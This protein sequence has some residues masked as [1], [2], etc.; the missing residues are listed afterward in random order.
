MGTYAAGAAFGNS[1]ACDQ[2]ASQ[3]VSRSSYVSVCQ[4]SI[5]RPDESVILAWYLTTAMSTDT[6]TSIGPCSQ[7]IERG[8]LDHF[9]VS[10][11]VVSSPGRSYQL[12]LRRM[13]RLDCFWIALNNGASAAGFEGAEELGIH[14]Q[15]RGLR[16]IGGFQRS[17]VTTCA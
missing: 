13:K 9:K 4:H 7:G 17:I 2:T 16:L 8:S 1:V 11:S 12:V 15:W 6:L 3:T 5:T 10:R 14:W